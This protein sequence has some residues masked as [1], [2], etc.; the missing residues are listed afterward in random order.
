MC[1]NSLQTAEKLWHISGHYSRPRHDCYFNE[2]QVEVA[3]LV[4]SALISFPMNVGKDLTHHFVR[5]LTFQWTKK[6]RNIRSQWWLP[7][8]SCNAPRGFWWSLRI[9]WSSP[10]A[11]L[12]VSRLISRIPKDCRMWRRSGEPSQ[13]DLR[14]SRNDSGSD[15]RVQNRT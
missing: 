6:E 10:G 5:S 1:S 4:I 9:C 14:V 12:M 7:C 11:D 3:R 2:V 13:S 8:L 15:D